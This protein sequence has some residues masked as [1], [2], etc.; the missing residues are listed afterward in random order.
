M[1]SLLL[2]LALP[3]EAGVVTPSGVMSSRTLPDSDG[4]SYAETNTLD[5][6]QSTVWVEGDESG[7][8]LGDW[9][10]YSFDAETTVTSFRIWNGNYYSYDFWNRHNRIK[11]VEATFSDGSKQTFTLTDEMKAEVVTLDTPVAT[12]SVKLKIKSI[13]RGTTFN[14]T[15]I[16]ELVFYDDQEDGRI[17]VKAYSASSVYPADA[18]GNYEPINLEDGAVDS[19][20]C[21]GNEEGDGMGEWVELDFGQT[22]SISS[23]ELV[24]GNAYDFMFFMK[25]NSATAM[26]LTFSDGSTQSVTVKSSP[27]KQT[28]PLSTVSTTKVK[29]TATGVKKGKEFNDLC[30]A[31]VAFKN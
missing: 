8:G 19:L 21:E 20:W 13:Y 14:D 31:E 29:M 2:A 5:H 22:R 17:P 15:V 6:K 16:S 26:D 1:T 4:V 25:G 28:I 11:E 23:L 12:T 30:L 7:S 24:N 9:V 27:M 18:D 10:E 3:A